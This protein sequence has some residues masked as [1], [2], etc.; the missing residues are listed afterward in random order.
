MS[1]VEEFK[2]FITKGDVID[3][4]VGVV[5]GL[6]FNALIQAFVAGLIT[7]LVGVFL[8]TDF[9]SYSFTVNGSKF[10][11]GTVINAAISFLIIAAVV[12]FLIVKPVMAMAERRKAKK[13]AEPPTTRDCPE[14]LSKIP[15]K[16][17]RCMY[18]TSVVA[19]AA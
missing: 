18:C 13:K 12:F 11:A 2:A 6:A 5:I 14:C 1:L 10:A 19:P 15:L 9:S 4:A 16:A 17:S 8:K 7:P 3:M